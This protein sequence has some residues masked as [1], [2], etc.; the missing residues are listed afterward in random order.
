MDAPS[1]RL[2]TNMV[3]P[4]RSIVRLFFKALSTNSCP[5]R[6]SRW[7][8]ADPAEVTPSSILHEWQGGNFERLPRRG[9]DPAMQTLTIQFPCSDRSSSSRSSLS[10]TFNVPLGISV[11]RSF[12]RWALVTA[13]I[14]PRGN[15]R[16]ITLHGDSEA[17]LRWRARSRPHQSPIADRSAPRTGKRELLC[18]MPE[19]VRTKRPSDEPP[20]VKPWTDFGNRSVNS[21]CHMMSSL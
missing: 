7:Q 9:P 19:G 6:W 16:C 5:Q 2:S 21:R 11:R 14:G 3:R 13:T 20:P 12:G 1:F 17:A 8:D 15:H 4:E 18:S 10:A